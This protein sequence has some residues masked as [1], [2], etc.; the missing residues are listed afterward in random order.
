V[1]QRDP[2]VVEVRQVDAGVEDPA[3]GVLGV[4]DE[5]PADHPHLDVRVEQHQ[6]DPHF[7][8][9]RRAVVL[10]V[11]K[12][13][14]AQL[15]VADRAPAL[16]DPHGFGEAPGE[17]EVDLSDALPKERPPCLDGRERAQDSAGLTRCARG[18]F[19]L[20]SMSNSTRSPPWRLSKL[21]ARSSPERWK[22]YST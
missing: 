6:V 21:R 16:Y 14:V 2:P 19:W 17:L 13:S 8:R 9:G 1:D 12:P 10:G 7:Q 18:P 4:I 3:A 15:H 11:E 20:A 22:K 5:G